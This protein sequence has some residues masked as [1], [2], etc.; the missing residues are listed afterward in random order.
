M[1]NNFTFARTYMSAYRQ[2]YFFFMPKI[3]LANLCLQQLQLLPTLLCVGRDVL[4]W[5]SKNGLLVTLP[6]S[7]PV[8]GLRVHHLQ[9]LPT[10]AQL[11]C[12]MV[13]M[14]MAAASWQ[15]KNCLLRYSQRSPWGI[16]CLRSKNIDSHNPRAKDGLRAV[17]VRSCHLP[18]EWV[19]GGTWVVGYGTVWNS[20]GTG[21]GMGSGMNRPSTATAAHL[22]QNWQFGA[23]FKSRRWDLRD[24][25]EAEWTASHGTQWVTLATGRVLA[26][27]RAL[28]FQGKAALN[29]CTIRITCR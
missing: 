22:Y 11:C 1:C 8:A 23:S 26:S 2:K 13:E 21:S 7:Q 28:A 4:G 15:S 17:Y 3:V 6:P 29:R 5:Q 16:L 27:A 14:R 25:S 10:V 12:L 18:G 24:R 20:N 9:L 19:R